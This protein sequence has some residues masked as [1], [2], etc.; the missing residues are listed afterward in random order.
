MQDRPTAEELLAAV[1]VFLEQEVVP[2]LT[3]R[4]QFLARVAAR[5]VSIVRRELNE[6]EEALRREW[7]RLI[8][9]YPDTPREVASLAELRRTV[10]ELNERLCEE[11]RN[12]P[13]T[14][15]VRT[16]ALWQHLWHTVTD[17]LRVSNP[18][19]LQRLEAERTVGQGNW[20]LKPND[21]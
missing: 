1:Q 16:Q 8:E 20:A 6:E 4:T 3:G 12:G 15:E 5:A 14:D 10:R 19:L 11:I 2:E 9:L 13:S 21:G 17:K 7:R 18:V